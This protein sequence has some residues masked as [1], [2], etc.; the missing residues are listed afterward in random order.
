MK[1]IIF[2]AGPA[3]LTAAYESSKKGLT[4]VVFEK[5][6]DVGGISKTVNYKDYLFDIGGHRI[7]K[8]QNLLACGSA[9]INYYQRMF[10]KGSHIPDSSPFPP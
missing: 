1:V 4:P 3:G 8:I 9:I 5:D 6:K 7:G 10:F 2:G